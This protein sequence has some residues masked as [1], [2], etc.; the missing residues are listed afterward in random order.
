VGFEQ[1]DDHVA[2]ALLLRVPLEQHPERLT[3]AGRHSNEHPEMAAM[4]R[5]HVDLVCAG[6][7]SGR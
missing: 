6:E 5:A 1:P 2:S 4:G 7:R 3:D